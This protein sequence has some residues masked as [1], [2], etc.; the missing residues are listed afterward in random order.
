MNEMNEWRFHTLEEIRSMTGPQKDKVLSECVR[1]RVRLCS[2]VK[3]THASIDG[4]MGL[5][6]EIQRARADEGLD[7]AFKHFID[8]NV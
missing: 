6:Y 1:E 4:L 3:P 8:A 5:Q 2:W 7:C